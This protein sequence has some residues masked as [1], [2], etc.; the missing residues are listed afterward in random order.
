MK[1]LVIS[2]IACLILFGGFYFYKKSKTPVYYYDDEYYA[3]EELRKKKETEIKDTT[4][5][6]DSSTSNSDYSTSNSSTKGLEELVKEQMELTSSLNH[7]LTLANDSIYAL[8]KTVNRLKE[9][10]GSKPK[11]K[12][13]SSPYDNSTPVV[14]NTNKNK[15]VKKSNKTSKNEKNLP[16]ARGNDAVK[17]QEFFTERYDNR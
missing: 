8:N 7:K 1:K 15:T 12:I 5:I 16:I 11:I 17:L 14:S 2:G 10:L 6:S 4:S 13:Q 3:K 9:E